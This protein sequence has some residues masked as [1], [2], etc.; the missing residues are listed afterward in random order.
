MARARGAYAGRRDLRRRRM[1]V[2][3]GAIAALAMAPG[4]QAE[5][6]DFLAR[7]P[8][9]NRD[10]SFLTRMAVDRV[11]GADGAQLAFAIEEALD[12][13]DIDGTRYFTVISGA[14]RYRGGEAPSADGVITGT[15]ATDVEENEVKRKVRKCVEREGGTREGKCLKEA[16]V[17]TLCRQRIVAVDVT[18]RLT[19]V[20]DDV[21]VYRTAR[22]ERAEL[23]WCP[24]ERPERTVEDMIGAQIASHAAAFRHDIAPYA[25][26]E[27]IRYR[28]GRSK[29]PKEIGQRFRAAVL[30][31]ERDP[32][33]A[34]A[35]W[36]GIDA[37]LPGH[38][39]IAF[40]L[41]LCAEAAG[42]LDDALRAYQRAADIDPRAGDIRAG[43]DRVTRRI[44]FEADADRYPAR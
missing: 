30:V 12:R 22:P 28:E 7:Y 31:S 19:R 23:S 32:Y 39:S 26:R 2:L 13:A 41:A 14:S 16:D 29:M 37:E 38:P 6:A 42:A 15:V 25:V 24:G 4:A 33:A 8:A 10:A 40:N 5:T 35:A 34:C 3:G 27:S 9:P 36:R 11:A 18:L 44:A 43:I 21:V 1:V 20:S 17:D